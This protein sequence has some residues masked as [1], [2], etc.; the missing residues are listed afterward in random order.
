MHAHQLCLIKFSAHHSNS[1]HHPGLPPESLRT[2]KSPVNQITQSKHA[3]SCSMFQRSSLQTRGVDPE[4][5]SLSASGS[6]AQPGLMHVILVFGHSCSEAHSCLTAY[7]PNFTHCKI[8]RQALQCINNTVAASNPAV[9]YERPA[10]EFL[11]ARAHSPSE[12]FTQR[13]LGRAWQLCKHCFQHGSTR[14]C[15]ERPAHAKTCVVYH[16]Q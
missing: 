10:A 12:K 2:I 13:C 4:T 5:S 3:K 11:P 8:C 1:A 16:C 14:Q 6:K 7:L 15:T 9:V